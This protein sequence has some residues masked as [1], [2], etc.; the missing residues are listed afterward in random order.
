MREFW[1][2]F[3]SDEYYLPLDHVTD[4]GTRYAPTSVRPGWAGRPRDCWLDW[5]APGVP[6]VEHGWKIHVSSGLLSAQSTLDAVA[7]ICFDEQ[8][9]FKHIA[10]EKFFLALHHKHG[11]RPQSGKFCA[12]YPTDVESARRVLD[13]LVERRRGAEAPHILTDRRYRDSASVH[14]RYGAFSPRDRLLADGSREPI[15][16]DAA[17][18]E[19]ADVRRPF[20]T[21]PDGV[22]DPF[23]EAEPSPHT[24]S[25]LL[26]GRYRVTA[27]IRHSN[28][29]GSYRA[30]DEKTGRTVFIKEARAHNGYTWDRV[31]AQT[32]LR[33][34]HRTLV[35]LHAVDPGLAPEPLEYFRAWEHEFLVTEHV[36]GTPLWTWAGRYNRMIRPAATR[37]ERT[38]YLARAAGVLA[39]LR[40]VLDRLHAQGRRFGDLSPGNVLIGPDD[41][42]RLV[43]FEA[44]S[45]LTGPELKMGTEGFSPPQALVDAGVDSD[46]YGFAA[47]ALVLLFPLQK[48]MQVDGA[49]RAELLR[50]DLGLDDLDEPAQDVLWAAALRYYGTAGAMTRPDPSRSRDVGPGVPQ[51]VARARE[52]RGL[53][54]AADLDEHP[55]RC[56][57]ELVEDLGAGLLAMARPERTD[58]L[59]PPSPRAYGTNMVCVAYG[60]AGVIHALHHAGIAIP[61]EV[62]ARFRREALA[63]RD[64]LAPGLHVG[65]AGVAWV[66]AETGA[67]DEALELIDHAGRHELTRGVITLE[68]GAAGVGTAQLALHRYT[69]D[70][71]RLQSAAELGELI[72]DLD[73]PTAVL[74]KSLQ[75]LLRGR[76]GV[77]L[78]LHHLTD[79]TGDESFRRA[80]LTLLHAELDGAIEMPTGDLS[81]VEHAELRRQ[82]PFLSVGSAGVTPVLA[83]YVRATGDER[84]AE[85]LPRIAADCALSCAVDPGLYQ[86]LAG[87]VYAWADYADLAGLAHAGEAADLVP[88]LA[89]GL[90]KHVVRHPDGLRVLGS[91]TT[92]Y[93]A[94]LHSGSAG[95]LLALSRVVHGPT[96]QFFTLDQREGGETT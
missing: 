48:L 57:R 35:D 68:G 39:A 46:D 3:A 28:A 65:T 52:H 29:G 92:R 79:E 43:D 11:P 25:V 55:T 96:G 7:E 6:A 86:G 44:T 49:G 23:I 38:A 90:V 12:V 4:A 76:A 50:R 17:G 81:F 24:G 40:A 69:G 1:L 73:D 15:L 88:R 22:V 42:V 16:V 5:S 31:D 95:V 26:G 10:A 2:M 21:L 64:R 77:A 56:L 47:L 37:A 27:A 63:E 74:G 85:A 30:V 75:G 94:D 45:S 61:E 60:T 8:V 80:G 82:L 9:R 93:S 70:E 41:A 67:L 62:S 53:P 83:R 58:W 18:R 51:L 84:C 34:E 33:R 89:G 54:T 87:A 72:R 78:F 36:P 66:L 59:F 71:K 14:Y 13:R 91:A 20:F 19:I 32:R